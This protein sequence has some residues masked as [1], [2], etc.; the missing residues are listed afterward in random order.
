M[1]SDTRKYCGNWWFECNHKSHFETFW[2]WKLLFFLTHKLKMIFKWSCLKFC[3][4][5]LGSW[6]HIFNKWSTVFWSFFLNIEWKW[7]QIR[8]KWLLYV[9]FRILKPGRTYFVFDIFVLSVKYLKMN[10][11]VY[12]LSVK[13]KLPCFRS[14]PFFLF[15]FV[16]NVGS[17]R[18]VIS[19]FCLPSAVNLFRYALCHE[20]FLNI[21]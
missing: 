10:S 18:W 8:E 6:K 14:F 16:V 21:F 11:T 13:I 9:N 7:I 15:K 2:L 1:Q 5:T 3:L 17:C 19:Y 20:V 12:W 4:F